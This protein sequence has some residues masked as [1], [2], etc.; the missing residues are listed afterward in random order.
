[1]GSE[2]KYSRSRSPGEDR[3]N[4]RKQDFH[5]RAPRSPSSSRSIREVPLNGRTSHDRMSPAEISARHRH[6]DEGHRDRSGSRARTSYG[7]KD[8]DRARDRDRNRDRDRDKD[9]ERDR[10]RNRDRDRDRDRNRNRDRDRD[11]YRDRDRDRD[12]DRNRDRDRDRDRDR[13]QGRDGDRTRK[14]EIDKGDPTTENRTKRSR[15]KSPTIYATSNISGDHSKELEHATDEDRHRQMH[16]ARVLSRSADRDHLE[17]SAPSPAAQ[18]VA[19]N[20][21]QTS[22]TTS[23]ST[24]QTRPSRFNRMAQIDSKT[25]SPIKPVQTALVQSTVDTPSDRPIESIVAI[26]EDEK[27]RQRRER[28][29]AWK[30][31]KAEKA[32]AESSRPANIVQKSDGSSI[33]RSNGDPNAAKSPA[34]QL[35]GTLSGQGMSRLETGAYCAD[36]R[37]TGSTRPT[38]I[39]KFG[40]SSKNTLFSHATTQK[41]SFKFED[42]EADQVQ[43]LSHDAERR[44]HEVLSFSSNNKADTGKSRDVSLPDVLESQSKSPKLEDD[45]DPLDAF[46]AVNNDALAQVSTTRRSAGDILNDQESEEEAERS[47]EDILALAAR[48]AALKRKDIASIDH[49]KQHYEDFRKNFYVEPE[50][51][52]GLSEEEVDAMRLEL[53][54]IVIRGKDCPK[55]VS[56]WGQCGLSAAT[57][58]QIYRLG[59]ENPTSIQAQAIPVIMSGRDTIGVAKTGSG[60]TMAFLLPMFRHIKDQR[61]LEIMEG[62]IAMILTPTRELAV[63]IFKECKPFLKVLDLRAVCVYGGPPIKDQIAEFKRGAEIVVCTPGRMIDILAANQ[64]RVTNVKR[65]TY[66][67]LDEADRMFD[68]GFEP[69]V[70]KILNN[71]RPQR[72]TVLFSATF[73]KSMEALARKILRGKPIEIT[74]GARSVVAPEITQ[75]VEVRPVDPDPLK[76][77]RVLEI[78]GDLYNSDEDARTLIFVDRQEAADSLLHQLM[79]KGYPCNALHGG[80]DQYDRDSTISDFKAGIFPIM[81]ATSV[82]ARGLDVKQLK[83]VINY[84]C[85][86]HMED[87]VHRVGRTGRAGNKGTAITF[88]GEDQERYAFDIAKALRLSQV[89]IPE[90]LK[91]LADSFAEKVKAGIEKGSAAGFGGKGLA[92]F[93]TARDKEKKLQRKIYGDDDDGDDADA[94]DKIVSAAEDEDDDN[95]INPEEVKA[96]AELGSSAATDAP[97]KVERVTTQTKQNIGTAPNVNTKALDPVAAARARIDAISNRIKTGAKPLEQI[98]SNPDAG[99]FRA[100]MEINDYPQKARWNVTNRTNIA[101]VLEATGTSITT[102]GQYVKP[103]SSAPAGV[104][105]LYLLV[106]G[107]TEICVTDAVKELRRLLSEGTL[108]DA[109]ASSSRYKVV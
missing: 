60:K 79:R 104:P 107:P 28:I 1:M 85:P 20:S 72:Q 3:T 59:Y 80:K 92:K 58:E 23:I 70:M 14:R 101:K 97:I 40:M 109:E 35:T 5:D 41:S 18:V 46:M 56:N 96:V 100:M 42:D 22:D 84:D 61:P 24:T 12:R 9:R 99:E 57:L 43:Q 103:G 25:T 77:N 74:V 82:A 83:L 21:A 11:R 89:E 47:D 106:E 94:N 90:P 13:S 87:Y 4:K 27:L 91:K 76:F 8:R 68:L 48:K 64:G 95:R 67:V 78:L 63:Q 30:K 86:N 19:S 81:V 102:Q 29:A 36:S 52:I 17:T 37:A 31:E 55:P 62:P 88:V 10:D 108:A 34:T 16:H 26:T 75:I 2:Q 44:S 105:K 33:S 15:S 38:H 32:K 98:A 71:V 65:V 6:H 53:D 7:D 69:Q 45:V 54:G 50:E 93:D 51:F 66:T 39:G 73:P 49:S